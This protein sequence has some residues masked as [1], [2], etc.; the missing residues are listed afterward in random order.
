MVAT[1]FVREL[2]GLPVKVNDKHS[3]WHRISTQEILGVHVCRYK[4]NGKLDS[5]IRFLNPFQHLNIP[6]SLLYSSQGLLQ[7]EFDPLA[8][9]STQHDTA[10]GFSTELCWDQVSLQRREIRTS[11]RAGW[12]GGSAVLFPYSCH[13]TLTIRRVHAQYGAQ[14]E[15]VCPGRLLPQEEEHLL[16]GG[17]PSQG[18]PARSR[19]HSITFSLSPTLVI[20]Q[21]KFFLRLV[22]V[23]ILSFSHRLTM[24]KFGPL[25]CFSNNYITWQTHR[26]VI[27]S[28]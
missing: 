15:G 17:Q 23:H 3:A 21:L 6:M 27:I 10:F 9:L 19:L 5:P 22:I 12:Q 26:M 11:S 7:R 4:V 14:E 25:N 20:S 16:G 1:D 13:P 8:L 18:C 28:Y 2:K 24:S